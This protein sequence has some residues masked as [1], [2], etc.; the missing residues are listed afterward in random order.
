MA[1]RDTIPVLPFFFEEKQEVK[2]FRYMISILLGKKRAAPARTDVNR[3]V[4]CSMLARYVV[5]D[6]ERPFYKLENN[7]CKHS[8]NFQVTLIFN[9]SLRFSLIKEEIKRLE[10]RKKLKEENDVSR[11]VG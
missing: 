11:K 6:D 5:A 3:C 9:S 4:L 2:S 8:V 1:V 7:G 10:Q